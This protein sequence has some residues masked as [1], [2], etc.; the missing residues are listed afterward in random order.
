MHQI[1]FL[2]FRVTLVFSTM[3]RVSTYLDKN[4]FIIV[5]ITIILIIQVLIKYEIVYLIMKCL[6]IKTI[7][8][9]KKLDMKW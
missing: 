7:A 3:S 4:N 6:K 9:Q 2:F 1:F 5:I 8:N